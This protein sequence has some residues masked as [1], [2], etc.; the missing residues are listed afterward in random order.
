MTDRSSKLRIPCSTNRSASSVS[1]LSIF[2]NDLTAF[3]MHL[4]KL[5][6]GHDLDVPA[7]ELRGQADVLAASAD[8]Q[9]ELVFIDQDDRPAQ[10]GAE[11]DLV[12][13]SRLEGVGNQHLER[14][15]PADD[16][17]F[18]AAQFVDDVL[19]AAAADADAGPHGI[20]LGVDRGDGDLGAVS[21]LAGQ[22]L[23]LDGALGDLGDF[24]LEQPADEFRVARG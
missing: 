1:T 4:V 23:D 21:G 11:D 20:H 13:L 17:D 2:S 10:Q 6:G 8:G 7:D 24:E 22:G 3:S 9:R 15:V 5:F 18:L 14:L 16:V 12:D 19:D